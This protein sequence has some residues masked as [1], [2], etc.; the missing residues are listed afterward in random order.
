MAEKNLREKD[1]YF[2]TSF[3]LRVGLAI[4]FFYAS[5]SAFLNPLAWVGFIPLFVKAIIP[6]NI[7]LYIHSTAELILGLWLLSNKK[8]FYASLIS[9]LALLAIVVFNITALDIIFRDIAIL[10]AALALAALSYKNR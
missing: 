8:V 9:A 10:F 6:A 7:F 2:F 5:I 1:R 4:V 3:F